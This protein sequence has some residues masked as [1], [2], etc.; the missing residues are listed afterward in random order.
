MAKTDK[1]DELGAFEFAG[2]AGDKPLSEKEVKTLKILVGQLEKTASQMKKM[3]GE[4]DVKCFDACIDNVNTIKPIP[5]MQDF[6]SVMPDANYQKMVDSIVKDLPQDVSKKF[7]A[8]NKEQQ[9]NVAAASSENISFFLD[10]KEYTAL[11]ENLVNI[12]GKISKDFPDV[13]NRNQDNQAHEVLAEVL[14]G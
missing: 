8:L 13:I 11:E 14:Q 10:R 2:N 4:A 9:V 5:A 1:F 12:Y 6:Y 7:L 3:Y